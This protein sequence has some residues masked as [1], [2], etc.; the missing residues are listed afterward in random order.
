[1]EGRSPC[2]ADGGKGMDLR[3]PNSLLSA[4]GVKGANPPHSLYMY[5]KCTC[6]MYVGTIV[7]YNILLYQTLVSSFSTVLT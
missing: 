7:P 6:S 4:L 3:S 5:C 2:E 1:V